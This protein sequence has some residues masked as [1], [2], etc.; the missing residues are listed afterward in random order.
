MDI[1]Q[2]YRSQKAF[3]NSNQTKD[4]SFRIQQLKK[5]KH[6]LKSNE[7]KL[8]DAIYT[9]FAK[10]EFETYAT[11]LA[12]IYHDINL[13]I[14]KIPDWSRKTWVSTGLANFPASSYVMPEPLGNTLVIGA[15]N[16][17]YQLSILPAL[18]ALAAGNTVILKPSEVPSNTSRVMAELINT[19]FSSEYFAVVEGGV[20]ET[21]ALLEHRYDKVFFTGSTQVGK[22][23]YQAAAKHLSPVTLELGGKSPTIIMADANI[24]MTAKR[25]VWAKF[26]NAGQTCIAPDYILVEK[27][28][29]EKLIEALKKEMAIYPHSAEEMSDHYLKIVN[30]KNFDRLDAMIDNSKVCHGGNRNRE[31]RFIE[32]TLMR[33]VSFDDDVMKEEIFGPILPII[34]FTD[35]DKVIQE[36]KNRPKPLSFYV[37]SKN[38]KTIKKLLKEISFG[39]GAIND[40]VMHISNS[41]LPFGGVGMS[42]IGSYHG[43]TGFDTFSHHKSILHKPFWFESS[44]KYPLYSNLK[45]KL[46]SWL[47]E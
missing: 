6:I 37:Y 10:S 21:T 11:E 9:D 2:L 19:N 45:R 47:V 20:L 27:S 40:S 12:L 14:K 1:P 28:V 42:G 25:I 13:F 16:Y 34:A 43:K 23:I 33:D 22:I 35:L 5:L 41:N 39:G 15:W 36:I 44:V 32:P 4:V 46:I 7:Q 31:D 8:Y 18:T 30:T 24:K 26:L 17:P 38:K 29:K 3:F